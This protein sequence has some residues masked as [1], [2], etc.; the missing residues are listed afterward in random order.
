MHDA[1]VARRY[2]T[3]LFGIAK[4][5]DVIRSVEEDLASIVRLLEHDPGFRDFMYAPYASR[6]EKTQL[7]ERVF[8][9]RITA[10]TMQVLRVLLE[11][12]RE[13]EISAIYEQYV[14]LRRVHESVV[15]ATVTSS[16]TL[17]SEE[18]EAIV[19]RLESVLG[20]KVEAEFKVE[21]TLLG[22][23]K[24]AYEN[25]VLDGTVRGALRKLREKLRYELLKQH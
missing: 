12:R 2:A 4:Q 9:D 10:L 3:A 24:V 1:R 15:Y 6:E 8:G 14:A 5:S 23:V 11:K 21:P 18:K 19:T 13:A 25:Y 17:G 16:D 22:G 20:K 7:A